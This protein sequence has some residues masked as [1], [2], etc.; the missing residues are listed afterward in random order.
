MGWWFKRDHYLCKKL[1]IAMKLRTILLEITL[2]Q[3]LKVLKITGSDANDAT[4][5][6]AAYRQA[7][8]AS[9]PDKEG[10]STPAQ[11][12]VN[13]A[14]ELLT[15]NIGRHQGSGNSFDDWKAK[16]AETDKKMG[17]VT[18]RIKAELL[19]KVNTKMF[20]GYFASVY[21]ESFTSQLVKSTPKEGQTGWL[22]RS[23]DLVWTFSNVDRSMVFYFE[24]YC[25]A[26]NAESSNSLGG[27]QANISYPL[28][29][30]AN[31]FVD[32]KKLKITKS[33]Y[34]RTQ[35][36]DVLSKPELSFPKAK[37]A[38][39]K[40]T[41]STKPFK[42]Q[43]MVAYLTKKL[44]MGWDGE[45]ARKTLADRKNGDPFTLVLVC[46]RSTFMKQGTWDVFLF[47]DGT[48]FREMNY[49]T[50]LEDL[51]TAKIIEKLVLGANKKST[52]EAKLDFVKNTWNSYVDS[53]KKDYSNQ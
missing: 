10:G 35:N 36:H 39:F 34:T 7:S 18:Q 47:K 6:K 4:K 25:N 21:G 33:D 5:L 37:L 14:Y 48:A 22:N 27:G 15:K 2:D 40:A 42:K 29:V 3:A 26:E 24:V 45:D 41:S 53:T 38:K 16:Q 31:G 50:L 43:D 23:V 44:E 17:E 52:P 28:S 11:Q 51:E 46:R 8:I 13:A 20:E 12:E 30:T 32:N 49:K 19:S 9:H 1:G